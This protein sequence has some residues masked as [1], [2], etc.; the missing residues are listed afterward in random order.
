MGV[1]GIYSAL[2]HPSSRTLIKGKSSA[3]FH[4]PE[5]EEEKM[6]NYILALTTSI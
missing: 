1:G 5:Q 4:I 3:Y 2:N 6:L